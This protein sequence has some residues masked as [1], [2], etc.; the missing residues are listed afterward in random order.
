M[1]N[2]ELLQR[3]TLYISL[4]ATLVNKQHLSTFTH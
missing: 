3:L 2:I 1:L 4:N